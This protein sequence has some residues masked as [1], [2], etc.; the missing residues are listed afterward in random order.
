[1][2]LEC[3]VMPPAAAHHAS[4]VWLHGLGA[5]G[6]DFVPVIPALRLPPEHGVRFV[7]PH[8]PVRPISINYGMR[9]RGWYDVTAAELN[10]E[11]DA[12]GIEESAALLES[13]ISQEREAGIAPDRIVLAGFS[14]GGAVALH[15]G[16]RHAD[17]LGGI[18]ALSTYLPLAE[19]FE[20]EKSPASL[21]TPI[22]MAH[23]RDDPLIPMALGMRSR[24][25][26]LQAGYEVLWYDYAMQHAVCPE[27]IADLGRWLRERLSLQ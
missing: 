10:R 19:R 18:A 7:F 23:G 2:N 5:D 26:L 21:G 25:L 16:V 9:M 15:C 17:A 3:I 27:Q 22:F 14:Q 4:V 6:H 20:R 12:K 24:D 11:Q 8:A 1:M 13:L